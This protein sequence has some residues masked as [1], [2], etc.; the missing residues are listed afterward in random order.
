MKIHEYL[1]EKGHEVIAIDSSVTV[2]A[3]IKKMV[4]RRI[5]AVLV[6]EEGNFV[7]MFTER[8][9]LKCWVEKGGQPYDNIPIR[10][11]MTKELVVAEPDNDM[12]Y[13]MT[14]MINK[15]IRHLPVVENGKIVSVLSIR[16]LVKA[17]VDNLEAEVHYLKDY[18]TGDYPG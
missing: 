7:G 15:T 6:I 12:K 13:A 9:V 17:L 10:D 4:E 18:F 8:D 1:K 14:I 5:G 11:V 3:A 2:S 16:D